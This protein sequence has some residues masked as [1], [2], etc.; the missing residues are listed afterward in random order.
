MGIR[1]TLHVLGCCG[2][3]GVTANFALGADGGSLPRH[4]R[5]DAAEGT[6]CQSDAKA[7][8]AEALEAM[9][10]REKLQAIKIFRFEAVQHTELVEQSYKQDPFITSYERIKGAVDLEGG[11]MRED[12]HTTWPESDPGTAESDATYVFGP[13][14]GV[15]RT[16]NGDAPCG[17]ASLDESRQLLELGPMRLLLTA[18]QA[19]DLH[20]EA[21]ETIRGTAHVVLAFRWHGTPVRILLSPF[22]HLPD[23]YETVQAFHDH[24]YQWGDVRQRVYL[25]NW[26]TLHGVI[27][28]TNQVEERN[29]VL[30]RSTQVLA[31]E[32]QASVSEADFKMEAA[33][34]R[35][36]A[37]G[38]GWDWEFAAKN[39]VAL[40][41]GV[42]LYPG[43]WNST[44]VEQE[45]GVMILEAP[46]SGAY[47]NGVIEEAKRKHPGVAIQAVLSTSDSWPHVGGA[48]QAV[49]LDLPVYILD[50]NQ[51]LLERM[52]AAPHRLHPDA[53]QKMPHKPRWQI[54]SGKVSLGSGKNRMELYPLRGGSTERQ[55]MVY[56][57]E[58]H[59]LY[60]SDTL[61]LNDDGSLYDPE[62]M[63]EVIQAV[64]REG[65]EVTTVF[66]MHQGPVA[67]SSVVAQV[68]KAMS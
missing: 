38:R 24:W 4:V 30:W 61:A 3:L 16:A 11:R 21:A 54:V 23:A 19:P 47:T 53:L 36:S 12:V 46:I 63:R 40:A 65:L 27:F 10:G 42:T 51:P 31:L 39:E 41:P 60:A 67:W 6:A 62:L 64:K 33:V 56:F 9:G 37:Q 57:P 17:L 55:Y 45:G 28:P 13:E 20:L 58:H 32:L 59:L 34:A 29:G 15:T 25:E 49:A 52:V 44:V 1:K 26:Q 18:Q 2:L 7:C 5:S 8:V 43:S 48:R 14:G 35:K 50:L 66:A 68:Q 22:N